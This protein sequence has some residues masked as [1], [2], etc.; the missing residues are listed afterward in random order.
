M[1]IIIP[2]LMLIVGILAGY[3]IRIYI[4][5]GGIKA[6]KEKANKIIQ[7]AKESAEREKKEIL[8]QA[9]DEAIKIKAENEWEYRDKQ[10]RLQKLEK[11]VAFKEEELERKNEQLEKF[12]RATY[13]AREL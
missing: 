6:S 5:E 12:N 8:L 10:S 13:A 3:F 11:R 1:N 9:K 2:I 7:E 4:N